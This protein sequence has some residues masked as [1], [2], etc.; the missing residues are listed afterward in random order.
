MWDINYQLDKDKMPSTNLAT[1]VF[2]YYHNFLDVFL[3]KASNT[4][5]AYLK[6]NY[7]IRLL[8]KKDHGQAAMRPM[9]NKKLAFVKKFLKYNLKKGFIKVSSA[10]WSLPIMLAIKPGGGICFCVN[11]QKLNELIKKDAYPI[12]LIAEILA[13]L[14]HTRVFTKID[15]WQAFHK[16]WIAAKLENL[17]IMITHFGAYKWKV[18]LF[19]LMRR[20]ALWQRFINNVLW[21]YLN[22]FCTAYLD[23]ILIYSQNLQEHKEHVHSMLVKCREFGIQANVDKCK[24]HVMETKYLELIISKDNIK[25]DPAKIKAI[26][27]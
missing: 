5:S 17:T 26:K 9:S 3:K 20:P 4:V 7:V 12:S 16:L 15:I 8:N 1:Q 2:E 14:S 21:E 25:M 11:Y 27:N 22:Q 18:L 13:Q 10:P 6:Y 24:F 19:G 23:N